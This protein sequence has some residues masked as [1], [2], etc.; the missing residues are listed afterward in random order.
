MG[1]VSRPLTVSLA[2]DDD[3]LEYVLDVN[4]DRQTTAPADVDRSGC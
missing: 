2:D 4:A 1:G 3:P